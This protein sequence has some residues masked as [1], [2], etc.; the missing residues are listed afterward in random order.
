MTR[1][2]W[3]KELQLEDKDCLR[4]WKKMRVFNRMIA[5]EKGLYLKRRAR[6]PNSF[7][8]RSWT[9]LRKM[10]ISTANLSSN[11]NATRTRYPTSSVSTKKTFTNTHKNWRTGFMSNKPWARKKNRPPVT[12]MTSISSKRP[13]QPRK[14]PTWS[15]HLIFLEYQLR[16][17]K[18][19]TSTAETNLRNKEMRKE[20]T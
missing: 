5:L 4:S 8:A 12:T 16:T 19:W 14:T 1:K 7:Q 20:C 2:V 17:S 10:S 13:K 11:L 15:N 6:L 3:R 9:T 18:D